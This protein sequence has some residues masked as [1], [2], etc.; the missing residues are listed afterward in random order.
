M[1][2]NLWSL[3]VQ[4]I[5]VGTILLLLKNVVE[6]L[7]AHIMFRLDKHISIGT[8]VRVYGEEGYIR[9]VSVFTITV[10]TNEGFIRIPTR[11]WKSSRYVVMRTYLNMGRRKSDR[12]YDKE[13][14]K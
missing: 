11:E 4:F 13:K 2:I 12:K 9:D 6:A 8:E 7:V 10:E 14:V 3:V 5:L 1:N